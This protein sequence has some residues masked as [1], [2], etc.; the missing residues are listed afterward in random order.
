MTKLN[1]GVAASATAEIAYI[2]NQELVQAHPEVGGWVTGSLGAGDEEFKFSSAA[3][4][5]QTDMDI[6]PSDDTKRRE[7]K[8]VY[9]TIAD[10]EVERG[11]GLYSIYADIVRGEQEKRKAAGLDYSMASTE[12]LPVKI[13]FDQLGVRSTQQSQGLAKHLQLLKV[14]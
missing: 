12:M 10:T 7:R 2:E 14:S 9:D 5:R 8:S 3:Y 6:S 11:W 4:R 13:M 1:D